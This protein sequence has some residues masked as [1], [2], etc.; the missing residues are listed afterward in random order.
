MICVGNSENKHQLESLAN[1][2]MN[3]DKAMR[4]CG[5]SSTVA[6]WVIFAYVTQSKDC[7]GYRTLVHNL[8]KAVKV[9]FPG[10]KPKRYVSLVEMTIEKE[11]HGEINHRIS[12]LF[13]G[14]NRSTYNRNKCEYDKITSY[15][16]IALAKYDRSALDVIIKHL[17]SS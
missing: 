1:A 2:G 7:Q 4:L 11:I 13:M 9:K 6:N 10:L 3:T 14:I 16:R 15:V 5:M 8:A 12:A 17:G